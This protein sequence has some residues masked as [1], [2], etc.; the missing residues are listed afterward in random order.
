LTES[1]VN[2]FACL[3]LVKSTLGAVRRNLCSVLVQVR[4]GT[5]G[6]STDIHGVCAILDVAIVSG[7]TNRWSA[8]CGASCVWFTWG[9]GGCGCGWGLCLSS[10][11]GCYH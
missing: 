11:L 10:N 7:Q 4:L 8:I 9:C 1:S 3:G 2:K 6:C 5:V